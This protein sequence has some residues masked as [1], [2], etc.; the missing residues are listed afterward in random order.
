MVAV[1]ANGMLH[2]LSGSNLNPKDFDDV[3]FGKLHL[4]L[5]YA[6]LAGLINIKFY[7]WCQ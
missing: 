2:A 6:Q 4:G 3:K 7:I 1:I 5:Q